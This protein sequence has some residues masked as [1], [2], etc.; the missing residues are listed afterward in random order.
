MSARVI[1][2]V[3]RLPKRQASLPEKF[4][5]LAPTLR[6]YV[7]ALFL[8]TLKRDPSG[9]EIEVLLKR[10]LDGTTRKGLARDLLQTEEFRRTQ[11]RHWFQRFLHKI[12]TEEELQQWSEKLLRR[13]QEET[14]TSFLSAPEYVLRD[15]G[16]NEEFVTALYEDLLSRKPADTEIQSWVGLLNSHAA[17]R[18]CVANNFVT[19]RETRERQIRSWHLDF[20]NREPAMDSLKMNLER[21]R[22]GES[23]EDILVSLLSGSEYFSRCLSR[24]LP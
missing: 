7:R 16:S 19:S 9:A 8:D 17:S 1:S 11:V 5:E 21:F 18:M 12:G 24:R 3:S 6:K 15:G 4:P 20:L 14:L 13:S 10:M 22:Q 23:H 2:I